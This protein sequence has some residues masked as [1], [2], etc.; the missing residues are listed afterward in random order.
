MLLLA[1]S[2]VDRAAGSFGDAL[3]SLGGALLLLLAGLALAWLVGR[4]A[5]RAL[6]AVGV[7]RLAE[8]FRIHEL[9]ARLGFEPPLSRVL[10]LAIRIALS[11]VVVFAA[12]SLL[13]LKALS[14]S[15]NEALLFLPN[16]FAAVVLVLLGVVLA[17]F[18][19]ERGERLEGQ[20]ALGVPL[21][22]LAQAAVLALFVLTALAQLS[23][24]TAILSALV[25]ILIVA[26]AFAFALAFGLGS[27]EVA[28]ELSA[29]RYVGSAFEVGQ[30]VSLDGIRGT[31][32]SLDSA[33]TILEADDGRRVRVPHHFLVE[34]IVTIH[35]DG[36]RAGAGA[37]RRT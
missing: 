21:G 30:T 15:L 4:L 28:R 20:M 26:A 37:K 18:A 35:E 19:R 36:G 12:L 32:V 17:Q 25:A 31:I 8:R 7:D 33:A 3:P 1:I 10:A 14:P 6:V 11:V 27:R 9:I 23:V 16:L 34:S 24:P 29:G 22:R 13:G 5:R 2:I